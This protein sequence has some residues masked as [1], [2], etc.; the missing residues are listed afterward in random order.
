[1]I[2]VAPIGTDSEIWS[3]ALLVE[4]GLS[5]PHTF[6]SPNGRGTVLAFR[7]PFVPPR[8]D[9]RGGDAFP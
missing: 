9:P 3:T 2:V 6:R 4:P 8:P 1:V 5:I 7:T